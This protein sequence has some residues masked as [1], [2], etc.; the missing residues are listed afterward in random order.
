MISLAHDSDQPTSIG[1]KHPAST[2][3]PKQSRGG[4][5]FASGND[6]HGHRPTLLG[7]S[8]E[9]PIWRPYSG[10]SGEVPRIANHS[11]F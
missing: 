5:A 3:L 7:Q 8:S 1:A 11:Q 2:A 4:V 6:E 9:Q 10:L